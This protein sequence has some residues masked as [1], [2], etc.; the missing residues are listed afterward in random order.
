MERAWTGAAL[1]PNARLKPSGVEWI[2]YVPAHWRITRLK[3]LLTEPMQNG[4]FKRKE[5]FGLGV[6]L[7]NVADVYRE[8]FRVDPESLERVQVSSDEARRFC[9]RNGDIFF[10]RSSLKSS[11]L[12]RS[13]SPA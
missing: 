4:L 12:S 8:D 7:I 6:P 9:V 11:R 3:A 2:G 10:V 13:F 1:D 5:H